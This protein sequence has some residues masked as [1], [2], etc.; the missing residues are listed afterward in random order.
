[1]QSL[2]I[3]MIIR[4]SFCALGFAKATTTNMIIDVDSSRFFCFNQLRLQSSTGAY[5]SLATKNN[6]SSMYNFQVLGVADQLAVLLV[7]IVE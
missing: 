5:A 7:G 1:M 4:D 3:Y 6:H 2:N